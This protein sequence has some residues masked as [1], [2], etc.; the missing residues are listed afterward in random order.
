MKL[1]FLQTLTAVL[2]HGS[3]A[4]AAKEVNLTASAVSLQMRQLEDYFG[5][6]LFDRSARQARPTAFAAE[7]A[8]TMQQTLDALKALRLR[9]DTVVSG[10]MRLGTIES[11]QV[12]LLPTALQV[13]RDQA[14]GLAFEIARGVS[15]ALLDDVKAGRLDAAVLVRP[16]SGGSS[17]LH[18][19]A[20][21]QETFVMIAPPHVRRGSPVEM[22]RRHDWIRFDRV[23][24]GGLIA[25]QHVNRIAPRTRCAFDLPG[26]DAVAAM[27]S[28]GL[29]VSVVPALRHE[30]LQAY[31][32]QVISLGKDA[33]VRH[34]AMVCRP[35]DAE[36]RRIQAV[37]EAF[38]FAIRRRHGE[39]AGARH[40][41]P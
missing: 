4:A 19:F 1:Q 33:P 14:P 21:Q 23:T 13:L 30:V 26:T 3:F 17:R 16:Q 28:A 11:A 22:L 24:T 7:V 38:Q 37:L 6:P 2:R 35:A 34:I 12:A 41:K 10:R 39:G 9:E 5:R 40:Q 18:W 8:G 27:V 32:L 15:A 25:A 20:L 36:G 29:G 31:P